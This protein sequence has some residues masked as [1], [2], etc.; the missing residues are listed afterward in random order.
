MSSAIR[1]LVADDQELVRKG[2]V[3]L[4]SS[5]EEIVIVGEA[6]N[7][8]EALAMAADLSPDVILM[9]IRMPLCDGIS[10]TEK[11]RQ[12]QPAIK[13]LMMT[14][15][16]DSDL[17]VRALQAGAC[18][19]FLKRMPSIQIAKAIRIV[20]E[21]NMFLGFESA[22]QVVEQLSRPGKEEPV[23]DRQRQTF[24]IRRR[25]SDRELE[26]LKLIGQG[27]TNKEISHAVNM[28]EGTIKNYVSR[29][30]TKIDA[31]DRIQAAL[32]A[33]KLL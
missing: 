7:G 28:S 27:K 23:K 26:V 14:T 30:F 8:E 22:A 13:I 19:Y 10:A 31:R 32:I 1:V 29:I 6:G 4:L 3:A 2:I 11:I 20:F 17:V 24:D 15:F 5:K 9:D 12:Q 16:D 33:Q 21:G 18:G 25:L